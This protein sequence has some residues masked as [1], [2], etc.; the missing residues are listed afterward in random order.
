MSKYSVIIVLTLVCSGLALPA[1]LPNT[2][3][4]ATAESLQREGT[5]NKVMGDN[6]PEEDKIDVLVEVLRL[7]QRSPSARNYR[8]VKSAPEETKTFSPEPTATEETALADDITNGKKA[9]VMVEF[10]RTSDKSKPTVRKQRSE[11]Q[12]TTTV[13]DVSTATETSDKVTEKAA[14][15]SAD[16]KREADSFDYYHSL[17]D[18]D[19]KE[20]DMAVA[21]TIIFRPLFSYRQDTA[22]RRRSFRDVSAIHPVYEDYY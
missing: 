8:A 9:V 13:S 12:E 15:P 17:H 5:H 2:E 14:D 10:L 1:P 4:M 21:E 3:R 18:D 7:P 20:D 11:E 22:A 19:D 6:I 16:V